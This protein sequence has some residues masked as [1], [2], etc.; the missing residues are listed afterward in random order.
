MLHNLQNQE[1]QKKTRKSYSFFEL[2]Q[3]TSNASTPQTSFACTEDQ[4]S[5]RPVQTVTVP[6]TGQSSFSY[7]TSP[8]EDEF[9]AAG[10]QDSEERSYLSEILPPEYFDAM[11]QAARLGFLYS[12]VSSTPIHLLNNY[13][14]SR[15]MTAD[16]IFYA[17]QAIRAITVLSLS[18]YLGLLDTKTLC[19][20]IGIP[21]SVIGL[22]VAGVNEAVS[23]ILPMAVV[24][25]TELVSDMSNAA[26][27]LASIATGAGAGWV[28]NRVAQAGSNFLK[29][30]LFLVGEMLQREPLNDDV[31]LTESFKR[32]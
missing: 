27:L 24:V 21:V 22:K 19:M 20:T 13:F 17:N 9:D 7:F 25:T 11:K 28:G 26:K 30:S 10:L 18:A 6:T 32:K 15:H 23:Q 4:C 31:Q 2:F 12:F 3:N 5:L 8:G 1:K 14:K 29:N 16:Q